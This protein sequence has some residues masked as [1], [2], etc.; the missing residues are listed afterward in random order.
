MDNSGLPEFPDAEPDNGTARLMKV[1]AVPALFAVHPKTKNFIRLAN[2]M[3][4]FRDLEER[5]LK[6]AELIE[7]YGNEYQESLDT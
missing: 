4:S 2:S 6:Y 3:I 5:A 7:N 1:E